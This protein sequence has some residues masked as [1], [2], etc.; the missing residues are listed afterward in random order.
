M[1]MKPR[2][3]LWLVR[4]LRYTPDFLKQW[5]HRLEPFL[6]T[7]WVDTA[8]G[9]WLRLGGRQNSSSGAPSKCSACCQRLLPLTF[10]CTQT[11]R[12]LPNNSSQAY[13]A[14]AV[15]NEVLA[16]QHLNNQMDKSNERVTNEMDSKEVVANNLE[17]SSR[18]RSQLKTA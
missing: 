4:S 10:L 13:L 17:T 11:A 9:H 7:L 14:T 12:H 3:C 16:P 2:A 15:F 1:W 5:K 6:D 8:V 18:D